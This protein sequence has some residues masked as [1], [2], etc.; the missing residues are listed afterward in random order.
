MGHQDKCLSMTEP[1]NACKIVFRADV[2]VQHKKINLKINVF[3]LWVNGQI[4]EKTRKSGTRFRP[5]AK[6]Y[7]FPFL[8]P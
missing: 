5:L 8:S 3:V 2:H 7:D 1:H 6:K 4:S